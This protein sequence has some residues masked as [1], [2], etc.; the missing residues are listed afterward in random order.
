MVVDNLIIELKSVDKVLAV[1]KL[2]NLY[3]ACGRFHRIV[4]EF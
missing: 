2:Q 4:F 1:H 3:E